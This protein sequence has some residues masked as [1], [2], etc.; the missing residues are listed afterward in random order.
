M[1]NLNGL[2]SLNNQVDELRLQD[3]LVKQ[4]FHENFKKLYEPLSE[5][6]KNTSGIITKTMML[7]SKEN[8]TALEKIFD[9]P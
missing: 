9:K 5:T 3:K 6:I 8:N 4:K 1:E 2:V 7:S